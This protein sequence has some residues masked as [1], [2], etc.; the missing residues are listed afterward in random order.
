MKI[1]QETAEQSNVLI[2]LRS[3][4]PQSQYRKSL[5]NDILKLVED[6]PADDYG[7]FREEDAK[8]LARKTI[9]TKLRSMTTYSIQ[10]VRDTLASEDNAPVYITMCHIIDRMKDDHW[11]IVY[12]GEHGLRLLVR[13]RTHDFIDKPGQLLGGLKPLGSLTHLETAARGIDISTIGPE[14]Q[15]ADALMKLVILED[16]YLEQ[17][18]LNFIDGDVSR[19]ESVLDYCKSRDITPGRIN[20]GALESYISTPAAALREGSL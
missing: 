20:M 10:Y 8:N 5:I 9:E 1:D 18:L 15:F 11:R 7:L 2:W 12:R 3:R 4:L 16:G 14:Y 17:Y 19:A 13:F 6:E